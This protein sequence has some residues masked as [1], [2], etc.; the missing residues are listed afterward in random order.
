MHASGVLEG[1]DVRHRPG[2]RLVQRSGHL[3][4]AIL[5]VAHESAARVVRVRTLDGSRK[6]DVSSGYTGSS[7]SDDLGIAPTMPV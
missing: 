6:P 4:P 5:L 2:E 7:W 3:Q 1:P